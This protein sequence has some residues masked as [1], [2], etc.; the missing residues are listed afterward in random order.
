M[1]DMY[2]CSSLRRCKSKIQRMAVIF[3]A[4]YLTLCALAA[5]S[6][7]PSS[8]SSE[9]LPSKVQSA[10]DNSWHRLF[11]KGARPRNIFFSSEGQMHETDTEQSNFDDTSNSSRKFV[12][13]A[14]LPNDSS[15]L[16]NNFRPTELSDIFIGLKTTEKYHESRLLVL[17]ETWLERPD[18]RA[19]T[20]IFTDA[21]DSKFYKETNG[22]F[23]NTHCANRH[24]RQGLCCKMGAMFSMYLKSKKRWWCT[25]DDDNYLNVENLVSLLRSYRHDKDVYIGR[26]STA[27]EIVANDKGD[28]SKRMVMKGPVK[29]KWRATKFWFGTGG[30]GVCISRSLALKMSPY[31]STEEFPRICNR[32]GLPDDVALGFVI[33]DLLGVHLTKISQLH[34][35]LNSQSLRNL[36]DEQVTKAITLSYQLHDEKATIVNVKDAVFNTTQDPTRFK[37]LHCKFYPNASICPKV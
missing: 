36:K 29:S 14:L 31:A 28:G 11:K 12:K 13:H 25:L 6:L 1:V 37:S 20:Y 27:T 8:D 9:D 19:Q 30:A 26:P 24:T 35:H 18:I 17:F 2:I 16:E 21:D 3:G 15:T 33:D 22:H 23:I 5:L 10:H 34:S 32:I 4:A 7:F